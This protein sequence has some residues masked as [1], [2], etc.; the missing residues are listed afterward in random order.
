VERNCSGYY[1]ISSLKCRPIY[2]RQCRISKLINTIH[3]KSTAS[4]SAHFRFIDR[5][6]KNL[7]QF[8]GWAIP[9][10]AVADTKYVNILQHQKSN[11]RFIRLTLDSYFAS[12]ETWNYSPEKSPLYLSGRG[13]NFQKESKYNST[14]FD[15]KWL[16]QK[17]CY[18]R[19]ERLNSEDPP[20]PP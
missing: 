18:G 6:F 13:W 2:V 19:L 16:C 9:L 14:K 7:S 20:P 4:Y 11:T 8:L 17:I 15:L 5:N 3:N 12:L 1:I 10:R